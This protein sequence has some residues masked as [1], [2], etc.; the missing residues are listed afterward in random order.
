MDAIHSLKVTEIFP[1]VIGN[2][3]RDDIIDDA[4]V[5]NVIKSKWTRPA[6][7][8]VNQTDGSLHLLEELSSLNNF[9][10]D[11]VCQYLKT[12]QYEF[13]DTDLY[14]ASCWGN[15]SRGN[16]T[17]HNAHHHANSLMSAVYY[18]SAPEGSSRLVME[19]PNTLINCLDPHFTINNS[20][21]S[22]SYR[23]QP[24]QGNC[25]IF[26]SSTRHYTTPNSLSNNEERI[27]IGYTFNLSR[28]GSLT[29][30]GRYDEQL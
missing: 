4:I 26:K 6:T 19:H 21:N 7:E 12:Y 15:S 2:I 18:V 14:I 17:S 22:T 3:S 9:V 13:K 25:V 5:T 1:T 24:K 29:N 23:I 27:S 11:G 10:L 28:L 20:Y 16:S 8:L 30:L